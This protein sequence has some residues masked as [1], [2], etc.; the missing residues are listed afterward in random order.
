MK[1]IAH[2][3]NTN[4]PNIAEENKPD[5]IIKTIN[6]GFFVELDLWYVKNKLYLGHDKPQYIIEYSFLLKNKDKMFIHCKNI[7]ALHYC[8]KKN[9]NLEFFFHDSDDCV[10]TSKGNIWTFPGKILT[11]KSI[12][13]MPE[14]IKSD[15]NLN[16]CVGICTDYVLKY[17]L[18]IDILLSG[19]NDIL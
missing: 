17:K 3:G 1:L 16:I 18:N 8:L 2:R 12:C 14:R 13:V 11:D 6:K 15:C 5:Y 10:L 9:D 7:E 19:Y 4:G